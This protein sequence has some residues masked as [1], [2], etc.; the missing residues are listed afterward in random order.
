[1]LNSALRFNNANASALAEPEKLQQ[2]TANIA[3]A[4]R[5]PLENVLIRN[6]TQTKP[7]GTT[8]IIPF[9]PRITSLNSNGTVVCYASPARNASR[10]LRGVRRLTGDSTLT[11]DYSIVDPTPEL[12]T[13]DS[14]T[15]SSTVEAEPSV[16]EIAAALS[17]TGV[18]AE[19]PPELNLVA[20]APAPVPA[21][22]PVDTTSS[23]DGGGKVPVGPVI[24]GVLGAFIVGGVI[25]GAVFLFMSKKPAPTVA[26]STAAPTTTIII[27]NCEP[28][29]ENPLMKNATRQMFDPI[30]TRANLGFGSAGARV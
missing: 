9:D 1:V 10:L 23:T 30:Q 11:I 27:Q 13:M 17:S 16:S 15:F 14:G 20:A 22:G 29:M 21:G 26:K 5:L 19:A 8:A 4:L 3:C 7:D 24:A 28:V 25:V 12:L 2:M 18:V 6:I